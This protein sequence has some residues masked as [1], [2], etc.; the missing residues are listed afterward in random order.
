M[1]H[2][3]GRQ[4]QMRRICSWAKVLEPAQV[5]AV[6]LPSILPPCPTALRVRTSR[7]Q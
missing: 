6:D 1:P 4:V 2:H 5:L 3:G 7:E